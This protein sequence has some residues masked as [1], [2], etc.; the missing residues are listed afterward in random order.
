M[1]YKCTFQ[2]FRDEVIE[3]LKNKNDRYFTKRGT[4]RE[5]VLANDELI[6][7]IAE[8]HFRCVERHGCEREW[9]LRNAC[10][11]DPGIQ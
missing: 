8:E 2:S 7:A 1:E 3:Y 11:Y 9:S 6:R 10:D 4:T 5:R